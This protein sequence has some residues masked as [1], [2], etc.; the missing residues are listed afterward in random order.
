M[1]LVGYWKVLWFYPSE[2]SNTDMPL[3]YDIFYVELMT[4]YSNTR[5]TLK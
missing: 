4:Y 2:T 5:G 3:T 1:L